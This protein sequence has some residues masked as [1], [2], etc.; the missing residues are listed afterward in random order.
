MEQSERI[1]IDQ[2]R[3]GDRK[4]FDQ[5]FHRYQQA[6]LNFCIALLKDYNEAE[7]IVQESFIKIWEIRNRLDPEKKFSSYLFTIVRNKSFDYFHRVKKEQTLRQQLWA[8]LQEF[9]HLPQNPDENREIPLEN[10]IASL[11]PKRRKII[12]LIIEHGKSHKEIAEELNISVN[13]VK[14]QMV[15][16][17]KYLQKKLSPA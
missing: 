17:K 2:L 10:M 7:N 16:A 1:L 8:N 15:K 13:T 5:L 14:N 11:P 9:H 6:T 12:S 3:H 4:A